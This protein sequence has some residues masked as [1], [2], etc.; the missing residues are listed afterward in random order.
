MNVFGKGSVL[1]N[2]CSLWRMRSSHKLWMDELVSLED[3]KRKPVRS[4][5]HLKILNLAA[6]IG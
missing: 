3:E 5:N 6:G 1:A 2:W 4:M